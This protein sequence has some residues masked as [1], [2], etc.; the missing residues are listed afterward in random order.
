MKLMCLPFLVAVVSCAK[1]PGPVTPVTPV[2]RQMVGL[3]EKFDRWDE[4]GDGH[5]TLAEVSKAEQ[6]T[7]HPPEKI[8]EFYDENG[9]GRISLKEAQEGL[10]RF[11]EAEH[12]ARR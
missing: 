4:N 7:G 1:A 11:H 9:D 10:E 12:A 5:L 3:L 8:V 2:Q 6:I